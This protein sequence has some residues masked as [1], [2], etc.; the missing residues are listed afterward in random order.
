MK[1]RSWCAVLA[2]LLSLVLALSAPDAAEK[3]ELHVF[4]AAS[5]ADAFREIASL[6]E[7][8]HAGTSVQLNLAGSQQLAFQ[9]EQGAQADVF[10]SADDRSMKHLSDRGEA[11]D[12]GTVFA[13][14]RLVVIVPNTNPGR[15]HK[16]QDLAKRGL[17]IVIG[18]E[19]VPVGHYSRQMLANL[20]KA[21]AFGPDYSRRVLANVVSE[22]E[23]VKSVVAKVQLGEADAGF[24]YRSDVTAFVGRSIHVLE[25]P[26]SANINASYPIA[27]LAKSGMSDEAKAFVQLVLSP[28]GQQALARWGFIPA[29]TRP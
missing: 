16:L 19:A 2:A 10:A 28:E 26:G 25:I 12:S 24:A 3:R 15:I 18:A 27:A 11:A 21:S 1:R 22:E 23:N 13:R 6:Y 20:S 7:R 9:I 4:A 29:A 17:K 14:N 5:L 8:Q